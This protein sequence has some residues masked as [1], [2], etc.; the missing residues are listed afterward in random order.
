MDVCGM[1]FEIFWE[2]MPVYSYCITRN[3]SG[4][5][6]LLDS[7]QE[8]EK[9]VKKIGG[10][11]AFK[12]KNGPDGKEA[13]WVVDVKSGKGSVTNDPGRYLNRDV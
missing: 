10:V 2:L 1:E 12:V 13:T 3:I 6:S 11:F 8:G 4:N 5:W 9:L 7:L